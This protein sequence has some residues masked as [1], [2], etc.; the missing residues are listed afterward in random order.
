MKF[1]MNNKQLNSLCHLRI[2]LVTPI[3]FGLCPKKIT[4]LVEMI[5]KQVESFA[6]LVCNG[7][8]YERFKRYRYQYHQLWIMAVAVSRVFVG[9]GAIILNN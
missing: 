9:D 5:K 7:P 8:V 6:A 1:L 3:F 4:G 2:F